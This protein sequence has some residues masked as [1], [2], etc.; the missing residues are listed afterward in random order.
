MTD[1]VRLDEAFT[2][3]RR[4]DFLPPEQR[5]FAGHDTALQIGHGQTNSQPRTVRAMLDL[6]DLSEGQRVLDV[7]CGSGWST[8]LLADLVGSDGEVVGVEIVPELVA[9]GR[10]NLE[11]YGMDWA[12][13]EQAI[14]GVLG[15]PERAPYD[16]VLVSAEATRV[17]ESLVAQLG[18]GGVM[19]VPVAG[20]MTVVR[21]TDGEPEISNEGRYSFVPLIEPGR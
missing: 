11:A 15:F 13:I 3:V 20:Q 10:R 12:G 2:R 21:R 5:G 6:L 18:V 16:R 14:D 4:E 8:A 9:W 17:P 19:V 1:A 7:G